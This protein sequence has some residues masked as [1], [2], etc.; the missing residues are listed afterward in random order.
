MSDEGD[1]FII[2]RHPSGQWT[3]V[4][5]AAVVKAEDARLDLEAY[6]DRPPTMLAAF[7]GPWTLTMH[8]SA[9]QV[10]DQLEDALDNVGG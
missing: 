1:T 9:P 5:G 8:E 10:I 4:A 3:V 6:E 2:H 7:W